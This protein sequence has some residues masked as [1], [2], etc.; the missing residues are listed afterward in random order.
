M[1][2]R[3]YQTPLTEVAVLAAQLTL[4]SGSPTPSSGNILIDS[5]HSHDGTEGL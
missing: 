1:K 3:F 5:S 4:L 2:N